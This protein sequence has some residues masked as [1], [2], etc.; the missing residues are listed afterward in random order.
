MKTKFLPIA[1]ALLGG[2]LSIAAV[3]GDTV[4]NDMLVRQKSGV[5]VP[6]KVVPP[7]NLPRRF[8]GAT[9][10]VMLTVDASG[11]PHD[12]KVIS[13][14]DPRLRESVVE[15]LSQWEFKPALKDGRPVAVTIEMPIELTDF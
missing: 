9:V 11:R 3:S 4:S 1:T 13:A 5:P 15:A 2:L 14:K 10:T 7:T 8:L 12:I 6:M